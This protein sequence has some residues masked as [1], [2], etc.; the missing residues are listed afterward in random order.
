[1]LVQES[2]RILKIGHFLKKNSDLFRGQTDTK[3]LGKWENGLGKWLILLGKWTILLG[4]W[5]KLLG[6]WS[7]IVG[8]MKQNCWGNDTNCWGSEAKCVGEMPRIQS[9]ALPLVWS[10]LVWYTG[11]LSHFHT[12]LVWS[13]CS[14]AISGLDWMGLDGTGSYLEL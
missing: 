11:I 5:S 3:L 2:Y 7:K 4:K 14:K 12:G 6:K 1:M 8:E 10:G 13:D 9:D